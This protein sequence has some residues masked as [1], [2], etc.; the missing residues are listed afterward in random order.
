MNKKQKAEM[1]GKIINAM[2]WA[3]EKEFWFN[4]FASRLIK[5]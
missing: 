4:Y 5:E 2:A 3:D 1:I